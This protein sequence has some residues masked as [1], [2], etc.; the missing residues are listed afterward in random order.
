[1]NEKLHLGIKK[2]YTGAH[3]RDR[4]NRNMAKIY[5]TNILF[6]VE[7]VKLKKSN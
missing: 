7:L 6:S 5:L 2:E 3:W 4:Q 1:M